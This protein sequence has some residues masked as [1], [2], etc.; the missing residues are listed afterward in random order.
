MLKIFS[1][2][3]S[4][5]GL[6]RTNNEDAFI[7]CHEQGVLVVAD[8]MGGEAAGEVASRIFVKTA[9]EIFSETEPEE[10]T[11]T[12][13]IFRLLKSVFDPADKGISDNVKQDSHFLETGNPSETELTTLNR[14]EEV[15]RRLIEK[16]FIKSN[17]RILRHI[18]KNPHHKGMGCTAELMVFFN[19]GFVFGHVGDS[20]IYCFKNGQMEQ[21]T[22]DHSFVQRQI[23]QGKL[24]PEEARTHSYRNIILRAVGIG[25]NLTPDIITGKIDSRDLFLLCSD[26]LTDM[27]GDNLIHE[28]LASA[29]SLTQKT[30][31]LI[32]MA[33]SHGGHDNITIILAEITENCKD[34]V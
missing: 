4:D 9:L 25:K 1:F 23:D 29:A 18:K 21:I 22:H 7:V 10:E 31:T 15:V 17:K 30:E 32:K 14:P 24:T 26:G 5:I 19:K 12:K 11:F 16:T 3:K 8:G 20:R 33:K 27:V 6:E 13:K 28:V 2:G 34:S